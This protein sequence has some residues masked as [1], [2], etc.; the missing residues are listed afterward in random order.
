MNIASRRRDSE[1]EKRS[2]IAARDTDKRVT[3]TPDCL[4]KARRF[5]RVAELLAQ[6][7]DHDVDGPRQDRCV[8]AAQFAQNIV[9]RQLAARPPGEYQ[10]QLLLHRRQVGA[11]AVNRHRTRL[12]IDRQAFE[13]Q[14]ADGRS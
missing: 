7:A 4:D 10:E 14:L 1:C 6:S 2:S 8:Y 3:A 11:L 13:T 12:G 5:D 9:T